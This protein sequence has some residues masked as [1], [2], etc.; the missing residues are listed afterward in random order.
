MASFDETTVAA[1]DAVA[2]CLRREVVHIERLP[3]SVMRLERYIAR[4]SDGRSVFAKRADASMTRWVVAELPVYEH[5][6]T[7]VVPAFL[8]V[9]RHPE[10]CTIVLED[11]SRAKWPPPWT[12]AD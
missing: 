8:G 6:R 10:G 4:V 3:S 11:L 12:K 5:L 7:A 2:R 9:D 1:R